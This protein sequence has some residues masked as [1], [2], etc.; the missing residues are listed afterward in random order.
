MKL[1]LN[2]LSIHKQ[3]RDSSDFREAIERVS[4]LRNIARKFEREVYCHRNTVN[5]QINSSMSVY[6]AIQAF[7]RDQ[8][9]AFLRW[10]DQQGPFW[11]DAIQHDPSEWF[12]CAS[13]VVTE[14][15][16]GEAAYC[17]NIGIDHCIISLTPSAWTYTPVTVTWADDVSIDTQLGNFWEPA[18]LEAALLQAEP[19]VTSWSELESVVISKF[20]HLKFS[21]SSF[22]PLNGRPFVHAVAYRIIALLDTLDRLQ[23]CV[24]ES[25]RRT[26][27][28][29][30][31]LQSHFSGGNAWFS[32]SSVTEKRDFRNGLTFPHP[33]RPG[34]YL[35][36][37]WHGKIRTD[38]MRVHFS[39]PVHSNESL[40]VVYIGPKITKR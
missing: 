15:A 35:F 39:W 1:L 33:E 10:F 3:F 17:S 19:P 36:C 29:N 31:L 37:T 13:E 18:M 12:E 11:E 25:G 24:D 23:G 22:E 4:I 40:Y 5:R 27:E 14:T 30:R 16:V 2:D 6:Q 38:V 28:G 32:D 9:M 8:K 21:R 26:S 20:R 7:S 34:E